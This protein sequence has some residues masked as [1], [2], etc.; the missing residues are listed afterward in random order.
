MKLK[1]VAIAI[2][3]FC[4]VSSIIASPVY[5]FNGLYNR[6]ALVRL[7]Y[8]N[9]KQTVIEVKVRGYQRIKS[10]DN[11]AD[12]KHLKIDIKAGNTRLDNILSGNALGRAEELIKQNK[13]VW[14]NL[15]DIPGQSDQI[16]VNVL[17]ASLRQIE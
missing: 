5:I 2:A 1:N 3:V 16:G 15:Q 6:D 10:I 12:L 7:S 14:L 13:E 9:S 17:S 11:P 4:S 8:H